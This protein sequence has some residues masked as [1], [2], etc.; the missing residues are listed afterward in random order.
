MKQEGASTNKREKLSISSLQAIKMSFPFSVEEF[1]SLGQLLFICFLICVFLSG[2]AMW[3]HSFS[4]LPPG[5][6]GLPVIGK[7]FNYFFILSNQFF[8]TKLE[9]IQIYLSFIEWGYFPVYHSVVSLRL[10][11]LTLNT[12]RKPS[13]KQC[14]GRV[15]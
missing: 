6:W 3:E 8:C 2:K 10:N 9:N 1:S 11:K 12:G 7:Y 5:P 15:Y 13:K 14:Y 4:K